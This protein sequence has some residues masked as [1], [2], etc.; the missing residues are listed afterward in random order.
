MALVLKARGGDELAFRRLLKRY[1]SEIGQIASEYFIYC[2]E[3]QD[4]KQ[5][6]AYGLLKAVRD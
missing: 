1:E 6:G 4:V 3:R 5:E 2:A